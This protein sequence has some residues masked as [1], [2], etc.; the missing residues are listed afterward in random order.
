MSFYAKYV[1]PR[2]ID[3][4][5]RN[6]ETARLRAVW[7]PQARGEVLEVGIGSGLNLPFYSSQVQRVSGVD[8]SLELQRIARKRA[9]GGP[10][11]V[12]FFLQS[13]EEQL[14]LSNASIDTVVLTWTLCSIPDPSK[15]L[16]EV[17]RVLKPNGSIIFLEHGRAPDSRVALWQDRLNPI[18]KRI[19]GGCHLDRKVDEI[20]TGA[21]FHIPELTTCYLPGPRP[22]TYTYQGI[23]RLP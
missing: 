21:G 23:A 20:I 17:K 2:V 7:I 3:L 13:A 1:L 11:N 16:G 5:M 4:A 22:L 19:G 15:A 6:K 10:F 18:W 8:P 12:E 14:P 9:A